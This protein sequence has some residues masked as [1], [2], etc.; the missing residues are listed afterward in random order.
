MPVPHIHSHYEVYFCPGNVIQRSVINGVEYDYKYPCAIISKPYTIHSMSCLES[1]AVDYDRYVISMNE[2]KIG[3][4][5]TP[6]LSRIL[7]NEGRGLF[8]R[9]TEDEARYIEGLFKLF[10]FHEKYKMESSEF[11]AAISL[12][13][14]KI[15]NF[16]KNGRIIEVGCTE[17]YVQ[18]A[19]RFI[20]EN[21]TGSIDSVGLAERF[22]VS[23]SKLDRDFRAA[24]GTTPKTFLDTCRFN[25]AKH[26]LRTRHEMSVKDVAE[27]IG[28]SNI[29]YF[30]RFFLK[31]E[32]VSPNVY[33]KLHKDEKE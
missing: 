2:N 24:T 8:F 4:F 23:R 29:T 1:G 11:E 21:Y 26:L 22:N 25:R 12:I 9:L 28:F 33:R 30:F 18:Q 32:G 20:S 14:T 19:L 7:E 15:Y 16:S 5:D 27:S 31:Y 6:M 17:S 3:A 13:L 10:F